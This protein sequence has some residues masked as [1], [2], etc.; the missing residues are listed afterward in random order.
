MLGR[1]YIF[2]VYSIKNLISNFFGYKLSYIVETKDW[3]VF[4]DGLMLVNNLNSQKLIKARLSR[5]PYFLFNQIIHFGSPNTLFNSRGHHLLHHSNKNIL[6]WF[7]FEKDDSRVSRLKDAL[8]FLDMIHTTCMT[9]KQRLLEIGVPEQ[10]IVVIP[11]GVDLNKFHPVSEKEK[12]ELRNKYGI[13]SKA[14]VVGSFQKDGVGWNGGFEPKWVKG[15]DVFVNVLH[16]IQTLN[17]FVLL[18]GPARGYVMRKLSQFGIPFLYKYVNHFSQMPEMYHVLDVY[19]IGSRAEGGPKAF[20]EALASGVPV[21]STRVGMVH[22][23]EDKD[24]GCVAT[25][26]DDINSLADG[27]EIL[28]HQEVRDRYIKD[29]LTFVRLFDSHKIT[30]QYFF[31]I[32]QKI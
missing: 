20:L 14:F 16:Q 27:L 24:C 7:H 31:E 25:S 19:L 32:Y 10:K 29:G 26:I 28:L 15:P 1:L 21:V 5:H 13:P 17:P 4:Q 3:A 8:N 22:D 9:T 18:T 23:F 11:L 12:V 6:T 30:K 2:F